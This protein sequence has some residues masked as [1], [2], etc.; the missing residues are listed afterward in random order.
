[1][2]KNMEHYVKTFGEFALNE[3][4][5]KIIQEV[6]FYLEVGEHGGAGQFTTFKEAIK[7]AEA[8]KREDKKE[9]WG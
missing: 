8:L 1:M 2:K 3:A 4:D 9:G 7:K 6:G 5:S